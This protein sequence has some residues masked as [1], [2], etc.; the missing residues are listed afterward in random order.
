MGSIAKSGEQKLDHSPATM[1]R[2]GDG[3]MS[4]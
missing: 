4:F 3:A 1:S 2:K